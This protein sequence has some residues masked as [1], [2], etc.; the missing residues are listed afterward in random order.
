M[1]STNKLKN[2]STKVKTELVFIGKLLRNIRLCTWGVGYV[3]DVMKMKCKDE[4]LLSCLSSDCSC[5]RFTGAISLLLI[6]SHAE[7]TSF[8]LAYKPAHWG[9]GYLA[10]WSRMK[11]EGKSVSNS[12]RKGGDRRLWKLNRKWRV[13]VL[14]NNGDWTGFAKQHERLRM[15]ILLV[16]AYHP[17]SFLGTLNILCSI[18]KETLKMFTLW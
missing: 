4:R 12:C 15:L 1:Q 7:H 8:L 17:D 14:S 18:K 16:P 10:G 3:E 2:T 5:S 13:R 11:R 9:R 6:M